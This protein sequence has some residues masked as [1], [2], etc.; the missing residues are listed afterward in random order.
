MGQTLECEAEACVAAIRRAVMEN[1][2]FC[3][4]VDSSRAC[5]TESNIEAITAGAYEAA[6]EFH[7]LSETDKEL[8][9]HGANPWKHGGYFRRGEEPAYEPGAV[10]SH[11]EDFCIGYHLALTDETSK[12]QL[13]PRKPRKFKQQMKAYLKGMSRVADALHY[14]FKRAFALH[15][16]G[17]DDTSS[18]LRVLCYPNSEFG[19]I[20]AHSDFEVFTILHQTVPGLQFEINGEWLWAPVPNLESFIV[21][22]DDMLAFWTNGVVTPMRHRVVPCGKDRFSLV[23]FLAAN[24]DEDAHPLQDYIEQADG[25]L[26][27]MF[28][29]ALEAAGTPDQLTQS[30]HLTSRVLQAEA[31]MGKQADQP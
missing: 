26:C 16:Y 29:E 2:F 17:T 22:P 28:T 14:G 31:N 9:H 5:T 10:E 3:A 19:N 15:D 12:H 7:A 25:K 13:W 8:S 30:R 6:T 18:I 21:I 20:A 27:S 1:G 23:L 4:R 24:E 11:V